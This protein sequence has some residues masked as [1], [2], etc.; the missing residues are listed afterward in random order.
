MKK[1]SDSGAISGDGLSGRA[2]TYQIVLRGL[3]YI[4][5]AKLTFSFKS[6]YL[7]VMG[8][9]LSIGKIVG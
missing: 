8:E 7:T 9:G 1:Q 3:V 4:A 2:I 6:R 5:V